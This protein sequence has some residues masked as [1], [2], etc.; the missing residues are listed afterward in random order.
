MRALKLFER[1]NDLLARSRTTTNIGFLHNRLGNEKQALDYTNQAIELFKQI[2]SRPEFTYDVLGDIALARGDYERARYYY[3]DALAYVKDSGQRLEEA[4]LLAMLGRLD[5]AI[6]RYDAAGRQFQL[7]MANATD[8][9]NT[10][11]MPIVSGDIGDLLWRQGQTD[12][13][14]IHFDQAIT[15]LRRV[16]GRY[17]LARFL[18]EKGALLYELGAMEEAQAAITE[19]LDM[20]ETMGRKPTIFRAKILLAMI[21]YA[22]DRPAEAHD[23]LEGLLS[24]AKSPSLQAAVHFALWETQGTPENGQTALELYRHL[25]TSTPD[26]LYQDR[27]AELEAALLS[28][29]G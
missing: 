10:K 5:M 13:A 27:L 8:L 1:Q 24:E 20:A 21:E 15:G 18:V 29:V 6:G 28:G 9:D 12:E 22:Q 3:E 17:Y 19:G 25:A 16:S 14:L 26:V 2:G 4:Q 23:A 11:L 7:A